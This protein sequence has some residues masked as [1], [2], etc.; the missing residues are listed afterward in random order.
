MTVTCEPWWGGG[1]G[2]G[3]TKSRTKGE[4]KGEK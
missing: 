3:T 4:Q 2:G 1:G